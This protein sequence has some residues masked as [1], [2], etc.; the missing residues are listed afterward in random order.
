MINN[1]FYNCLQRGRQ[2]E[3]MVSNAFRTMGYEVLD[4]SKSAE[5]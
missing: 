4:V 5:Y 1:D 3:V 2:A